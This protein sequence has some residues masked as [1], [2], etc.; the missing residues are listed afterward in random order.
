MPAKHAKHAKGAGKILVK[1]RLGVASVDD[2]RLVSDF[3]CF[4]YLAGMISFRT[5][6]ARRGRFCF[7]LGHRLGLHPPLDHPGGGGGGAS[8]KWESGKAG[9]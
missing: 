7:R 2:G 1:H 8:R 3:A 9:K 4:A 6:I 5:E